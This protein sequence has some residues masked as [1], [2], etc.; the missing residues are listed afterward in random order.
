MAF[1]GVVREELVVDR[2]DESRHAGAEERRR[3]MNRV[4]V[5][6]AET[7]KLAQV[8]ESVCRV[9]LQTGFIDLG[10]RH[11][12]R[13]SWASRDGTS[14][15]GDE[16][17]SRRP[18]GSAMIR[19]EYRTSISTFSK[20]GRL[21]EERAVHRSACLLL[22]TVEYAFGLA[23]LPPSQPPVA[24]LRP[25][26]WLPISG[27]AMRSTSSTRAVPGERTRTGSSS[28][29]VFARTTPE[30]SFVQGLS[31]SLPPL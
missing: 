16:S 6:G 12:F 20:I 23:Q 27:G 13:L 24:A 22:Q 31:H 10:K 14:N 11:D 2:V 9:G 4:D 19:P 8:P 7:Y 15:T 25:H 30:G 28:G 1:C 29:M 21:R 26:S 3:R 18:I 17:G 5:V